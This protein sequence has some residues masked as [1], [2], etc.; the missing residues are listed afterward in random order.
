V[1]AALKSL[2]G[3]GGAT[4]SGRNVALFKAWYA[5]V[6]IKSTGYD[7]LSL[8]AGWY[9]DALIPAPVGEPVRF[10]IPDGA[11]AIG[12][13]QHNQT[14]WVDIYVPRDPAE[15]PPG[16]YRGVLEVSWPGGSRRI[17]VDLGV[18]DF[19]LPDEVHCHGDVWNESALTMAPERE[20]RFYQMAHRHRFHPGVPRYRPDIKV[21]GT[22]VAI[23]WTSYDQRLR[24]FFDGSAFT[25]A[26]GYW[27]PGEG[28]PIDHI[29]LPFDCEKRT[30]PGRQWPISTPADGPNAEY[31]A[32]WVE[33]GR[34]FR[35][36]FDADPTW[37]RVKKVAFIDALDESYDEA[38]Y[39]KMIYYCKLLRGGM[40]EGWFQYRIDGG[41]SWEAMEIL[42]PYVDLWVCHTIGFDAKKM[43]HFRG[44]GVEPWFYGPMI[45]EQRR[46]SACGSNTFMDLDLLTCRGIGWA[47]WKHKCGYCE[48]EFD[49]NADQAWT[50]PVNY[51]KGDKTFNGSG[52]FIYHGD[53]L[54]T[55]DPIPSIRLKAHRRGFQDYEYFW[56]LDQ[57]GEGK[58]AERLVDAVV[59]GTPF[60]AESVGN[61]EIWKN[62]P[63]A[64]DAVRIE[65][66]NRLGKAGGS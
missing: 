17:D 33:T 13:D 27:G 21:K 19:A 51:R 18:W 10:D 29:L 28:V 52:L 53:A 30:I 38:A 63:E 41:Y 26:C 1:S 64:W 55:T 22:D 9:P 45:Y 32:V 23:D 48:W 40:G 42:H 61:V 34:Q 46:N 43:A 2:R 35:E 12:A 60:G 36:H 4:I 54:G 24:K 3:P 15:A 7:A 25:A 31:E 5:H 50:D 58:R 56:L 14:I 59:H 57:A 62:N 11:N 49:W 65:I 6:T 39:E 16:D 8:G 20:M 44:K 47:A 66:G 37:R